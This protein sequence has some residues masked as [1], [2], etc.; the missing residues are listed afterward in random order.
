VSPQSSVI[1]F[2]SRLAKGYEPPSL[3]CY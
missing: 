2:Q 1:S 3:L